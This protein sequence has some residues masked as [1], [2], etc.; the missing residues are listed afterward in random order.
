MSRIGRA[1]IEIPVG[2][3]V[4]L[5]DHKVF[6]RGPRGEMS[7]QVH[8]RLQVAAEGNQ[9][10][11][12]RSSD[13]PSDRALHGLTRSLLANMV[14]GVTKGYEKRLELHSSQGD[15]YR[16]QKQ[17]NNLVFQ[18][19]YSHTI[20]VVPKPGIEF[21]VETPPRTGTSL[22]SGILVV[23]GNSKEDV[24]QQAA[25]IR[26]L[27]RPEPYKGKGIRY[28]GEYVRRKAG[29]AGKAGGKGAKGKK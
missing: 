21:R 13:A 5:A 24:G 19:G 6:V 9:L 11:V 10:L 16:V 1:P 12:T 3:S 29:K 2:V 20:E 18:L 28:T 22:I 8:E 4:D 17:G 15:V 27:R 26:S 14:T 25:E 23:S 7:Q